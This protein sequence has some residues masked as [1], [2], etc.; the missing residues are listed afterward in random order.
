MP[1]IL[2]FPEILNLNPS[3]T[4]TSLGADL[5]RLRMF[6][7]YPQFLELGVG[8]EGGEGVEEEKCDTF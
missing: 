7:V 1:E 4:Q 5:C 3:T 2:I 6:M 8:E